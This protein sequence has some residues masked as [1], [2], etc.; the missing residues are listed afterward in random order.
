MVRH[1]H[2]CMAHSILVLLTTYQACGT[3]QLALTS[4][5]IWLPACMS[6]ANIM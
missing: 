2:N 5:Y 6:A 3:W 4:S 1:R